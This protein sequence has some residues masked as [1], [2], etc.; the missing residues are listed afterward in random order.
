M[1]G[2]TIGIR[3]NRGVVGRTFLVVFSDGIISVLF[4]LIIACFS[5]HY[6]L[7][8][9]VMDNAAANSAEK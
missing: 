6:M 5:K 7:F 2:V 1:C 9:Q 4:L 3:D 8:V